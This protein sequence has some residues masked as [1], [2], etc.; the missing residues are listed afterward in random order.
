MKQITVLAINTGHNATAGLLQNGRI[1]GLVSEERF[2]RIKNYS[3]F[4]ELSIRWLL[5]SAGI[6]IADLDA[7][8]VVNTRYYSAS[9]YSASITQKSAPFRFLVKQCEKMYGELEY[10]S[11]PFSKLLFKTNDLLKNK[12]PGIFA[13]ALQKNEL[14]KM[15]IPREKIFFVNHHLCHAYTAYFGQ[16]RNNKN[17]LVLTL[18]CEGDYDCSTV[19]MAK[20]FSMTRIASTWQ[21]DSLGHIYQNTT[22]FLGMTPLEHEYKVMGLAPYATQKEK[23][24]FMKTYD[25]IFKN[26]I[27]LDKKHP[28]TFKSAFPMNRFDKW[29]RAKA[30]GERFDN[31]AGAVQYLTEDLAKKWVG[32]AV[33]KTRL[34]EV[35]C[36]GG[37]FMNVKM[38]MVLAELPE[39]KKLHVFPSS[40][41]ESN[42]IGAAYYLYLKL[43]KEMGCTPNLQ[44]VKELYLGPNYDEDVEAFIKK[45]NLR[46]RYDVRET[47]AKMIAEM[48]AKGEI[49]ARCTGPMEWGA[50]SLGNRAILANPSD[51]KYIWQIN[52]QIKMR[53]FWMPF[54]P[55]IL[56][57][58][59][60]DYIENPKNIE[61]PY[62]IMAF[63]S[64][65]L[66]KKELRAAMH[67]A[68]FTIRPQVLERDWNPEYYDIIK[69]FENITGIGGVLNTSFNLHGKPIV[70]SPEDA[71]KETFENS[72][73]KHLILGK[74]LISKR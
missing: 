45:N 11:G 33:K 35:F 22:R 46:E 70:A 16:A 12:L 19:S 51:L 56:K 42:P 71:V 68:D 57:E 5:E 31:I 48:L 64:T 74:Y 6:T 26:V 13:I 4:P 18:D 14:E 61:A 17:S 10:F 67:Q 27:W 54:A 53:D 43:C 38:N 47:N 2:N 52:E 40:G 30:V 36:G 1:V 34:H 29:L 58:R 37:V 59:E 72:G 63:R 32:A 24:Y 15:G 20:G 28:L 9:I 3:G 62:M 73:L 50:R 49:V 41:D 55:T 25:K 39:V 69:E 8:A 65:E 21:Y 44:P 23:K 60:H 7:V 66:A